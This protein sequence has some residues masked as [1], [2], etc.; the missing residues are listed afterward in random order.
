[1]EKK[2]KGHPKHYR[3]L[4]NHKSLKYILLIQIN[5]WPLKHCH[6]NLH[7][8]MS[9]W[10]LSYT[11]SRGQDNFGSVEHQV[12]FIAFFVLMLNQS[13]VIDLLGS[14]HTVHMYNVPRSFGCHIY[15]ILNK[16]VKLSSFTFLVTQMYVCCLKRQQTKVTIPIS[17][18]ITSSIF[19]S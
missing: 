5:M 19:G 14:M 9:T 3:W 17:L 15:T 18:H 12:V 1:M 2:L 16:I 7:M 8:V 4:K 11:F 10:L 6:L 13:N